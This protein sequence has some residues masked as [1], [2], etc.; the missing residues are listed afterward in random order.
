MKLSRGLWRTYRETPS[1]AKIPSHRLMLRAG[2][3]HKAASGIYNYLPMGY[4]SIRKVENIVRQEM[5]EA[6]AQEVLMSVVT[7]GQLW[8]ESGRWEKIGDEM[9]SFQD[10]TRRP[11][12]LSPTNEE[13]VTDL[14]RSAVKSHK[15]LPLNL[16][17]INTKFRDE[18]RP[19]FGLLRSREFTM[20]DAYSFDIDQAGMESS[21]QTMHRTYCKIFE[22]CGLEYFVVE[23]D[24]GNMADADSKTHEFQIPAQTGEDEIVFCPRTNYAANRECARTVR[25][26]PPFNPKAP[27]KAVATPQADTIEKVCR[28]L[29]IPPHQ[30]VKSL[31]YSVVKEKREGVVLI[32][33]LGD[34]EL[35]EVKLKNFLRAEHV[36]PARDSV[37]KRHRLPKGFIGAVGLPDSIPV[38][39]DQAVDL[40][41]AY[42]TGALKE[43]T[44]WEGFVPARDVKNFQVTDLRLSQP[45]DLAPGN[46]PVQLKRGIE[47]G[48]IFQLNDLYSK[49]MGA[50]VL[51]PN[52]RQKAPLMGCYGIG[53]TRVVAAAIEQNHDE[54]GIVWPKALSPYDLHL[55]LIGKSDAPA[56]AAENLYNQLRENHQILFD[57]RPMGAGAKLKDA[58]LLGLPLQII[59]GEK[60]FNTSKKVEVVE[61]KSKARHL[62][63]PEDLPDALARIHRNV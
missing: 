10:K 59:V 28:F 16:Y 54:Q 53:I 48:H 3:I 51:D 50:G 57:D 17:Q 36:L 43:D 25:P 1:D 30:T 56:S 61:R 5:D 60:T 14:F 52:G 18:I 45:N 8:R 37:L 6:G 22:R 13:A 46:T 15:Q 47:V 33:L 20:K 55:I 23:A 62:V 2:L 12:C 58:D 41:A 42:A 31:V 21:Y 63:A 19:R 38:I 49:A 32:Q 40:E 26:K 11:L 4:R 44:H 35:S 7:P 34:D 29:N 39:F 27:L 9:L 24:A